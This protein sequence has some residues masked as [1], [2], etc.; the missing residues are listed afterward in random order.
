MKTASVAKIAA[1]IDVYLEASREQPVLIT[2][3]GKPIAVLVAV[4]DQ[5]EAEQVAKNGARLLRSVFQEAHEQLQKGEGVLHD[6][7]WRKV[8]Q[9]RRRRV[10]AE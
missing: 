3:N 5:A 7:F 1:H 4:K 2:R 8:A 10:R 9:G 6:E